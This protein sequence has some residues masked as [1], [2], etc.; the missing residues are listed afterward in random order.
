MR[1]FLRGWARGAAVM[2]LSTTTGTAIY[3]R[4]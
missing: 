3:E 2:N 1:Q 4:R